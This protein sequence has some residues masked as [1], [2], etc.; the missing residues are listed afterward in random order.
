MLVCSQVNESFF[1]SCHSMQAR[2][3]TNNLDLDAVTEITTCPRPD[4]SHETKPFNYGLCCYVQTVNNTSEIKKQYM[5]DVTA[6]FA[7]ELKSGSSFSLVSNSDKCWLVNSST[8]GVPQWCILV[9]SSVLLNTSSWLSCT[10]GYWLGLCGLLYLMSRATE[11]L[12][13]DSMPC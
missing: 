11:I 6:L 13:G 3:Q 12:Y 1:F 8:C 9:R 10:E 4:A 2:D 5:V 7:D